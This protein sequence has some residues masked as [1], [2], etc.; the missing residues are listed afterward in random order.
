MTIY[1]LCLAWNWE[2]DAD[3]VALLDRACETRDLSLFQVTPDNVEP[4]KEALFR[5]EAA[6]RALFDRASDEDER[7]LPIVKWAE[8][9]AACRINPCELAQRSWNKAA[10][11]REFKAAGLQTPHTIVLPAY[12]TEPEPARENLGRL[13]GSFAIKPAHGGGGKGV[14]TEAN[15]WEQVLE[16]RQEFPD[17]QYLLQAHVMPDGLDSQEA[18]FR[19]IYCAGYSYPFWWGTQTHAYQL[20]TAQE[21]Q[22][23]SL[24]SLWEIAALIAEVCGLELF[25][26]EIALTPAGDFTVVDYINDP[27]DLRLR[28]RT[29]QGIPDHIV[30]AIAHRLAAK[31]AAGISVME[32]DII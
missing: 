28:S 16:V 2:Y 17:D 15:S 13:G 1:D 7:F 8:E 24:E 29:P 26:T 6:F 23:Y 5:G 21:C 3:F 20:V 31:V 25:S 14:V 10:M 11:H 30:D 27:I 4:A 9:Q 12:H 22:K 19:V 18:W 32:F